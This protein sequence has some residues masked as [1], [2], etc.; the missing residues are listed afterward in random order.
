MWQGLREPAEGELTCVVGQT[1]ALTPLSVTEPAKCTV[2]HY[3][4]GLQRLASGYI[5]RYISAVL[6]AKEFTG[7]IS[8]SF[9]IYTN[10]NGVS[11]SHFS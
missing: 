4:W 10:Q 9:D 7:M 3:P 8:K 6:W 11:E 2:L 5:F 1:V